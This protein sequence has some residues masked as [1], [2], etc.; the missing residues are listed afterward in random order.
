MED[1]YMP[2]EGREEEEDHRVIK[3]R[4]IYPPMVKETIWKALEASKVDN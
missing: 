3:K 4:K 1:D 2:E